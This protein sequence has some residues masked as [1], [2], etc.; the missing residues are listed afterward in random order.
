MNRI[1]G[2]AFSTDRSIPSIPPKRAFSQIAL[3]L[4]FPQGCP[5]C[6]H[7]H[8]GGWGEGIVCPR[9]SDQLNPIITSRCQVCGEPFPDRTNGSRFQCSNC[10]NRDLAFDFATS[11]YHNRGVARDMIHR[12]KYQRQL[13]LR[14]PIG[15]MI[16][17]AIEKDERIGSLANTV[18]VPVP[19]HPTRHRER[20]FNQAQE[21][22][23]VAGKLLGLPVVKS[24][25]RL[26]PT[27]R[28]THLG[29]SE[30]LV[31]LEGAFAPAQGIFAPSPRKIAGST[32]ILV[33]DVLT[34]GATAHHAT[35]G[36][37][38]ISQPNRVIIATATR[39]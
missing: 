24:L 13:W 1:S 4:I 14:N 27:P 38:Q 10:N 7:Q 32:V 17:E 30:R 25:I 6:H 2:K 36:I 34:T 33:D 29:R 11:Q 21:I 16:A 20:G 15:R 3:D 5:S 18:L 8:R 31:N 28:Q 35:L 12:L 22:A 9:C 39:A 19:A 23:A 26:F 37:L